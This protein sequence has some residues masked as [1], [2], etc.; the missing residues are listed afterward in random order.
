MEGATLTQAVGLGCDRSPL[1]GFRQPPM[2]ALCLHDPAGGLFQAIETELR[3][4]VPNQPLAV[5]ASVGLFEQTMPGVF[6]DN[7]GS[8]I[9]QM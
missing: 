1:W 9:E 5:Q 3:I 8:G 7:Q 6:H 4:A 2:R